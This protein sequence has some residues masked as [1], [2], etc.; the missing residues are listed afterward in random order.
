MSEG[1]GLFSNNE[2]AEKDIDELMLAIPQSCIDAKKW[3]KECTS[4]KYLQSDQGYDIEQITKVMKPDI[5][6][7]T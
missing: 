3:N 6:L 5:I 7:V 2:M 1:I 4:K